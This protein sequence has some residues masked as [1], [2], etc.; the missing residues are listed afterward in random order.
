MQAYCSIT[1]PEEK[2]GMEGKFWIHPNF[3]KQTTGWYHPCIKLENDIIESD[4]I[5]VKSKRVFT[6]SFCS[7]FVSSICLITTRISQIHILIS[8]HT[9]MNYQAFVLTLASHSSILWVAISAGDSGAVC[10]VSEVA[11][12]ATAGNI[13]QVDWASTSIKMRVTEGYCICWYKLAQNT[14]F[15]RWFHYALTMALTLSR[16]AQLSTHD[17]GIST[18]PGVITHS[19]PHIVNTD[20]HSAFICYVTTCQS[21]LTIC[22]RSCCM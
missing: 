13:V 20:L 5:L 8:I 18:S 16:E 9:V 12:A 6:C 14:S 21:E 7:V 3:K 10:T 4:F 22:T 2:Y 11:L 15:F 1:M 19:S 17:S